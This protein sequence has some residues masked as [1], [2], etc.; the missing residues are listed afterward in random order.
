MPRTG[1]RAAADVEPSGWF[2]E[3]A[4]PHYPDVDDTAMVAMAL[5]RTGNGPAEPAVKRAVAWLLAMQNDDGGWAAFDRTP[6][7]AGA[8][9]CAVRG[10]QCDPGSLLPGHHGRCAG[11]PGALRITAAR[12][13]RC[14]GGGFHQGGR[15][16]GDGCWFGRWGVNYIYGT[17]QTLTG[18]RSVGERM[19]H[20]WI[21]HA[22]EWLRSV[23]KQDGSFGESCDTYEN[24][25]L[26][27]RGPG[28][29][30]ADG[31]GAMGLDGGGGACVGGGC[32]HRKGG[33]VAD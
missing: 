3:F 8:G 10:S 31:L 24:P 33:A 29:A 1:R 25:S 9:A 21:R 15:R 17:W 13:R 32:A 4:N 23:Q 5:Q 27:G 22:A 30:L 28:D 16:T 12:I 14:A 26:K 7:Q 11:V 18:L 20:K 6:Q 19:D 2:F